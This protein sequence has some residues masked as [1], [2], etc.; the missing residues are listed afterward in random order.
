MDPLRE[1]TE[2]DLHERCRRG[3]DG[4]HGADRFSHDRQHLVAELRDCEHDDDPHDD[5][6]DRQHQEPADM[7]VEEPVGLDGLT[8]GTTAHGP[9]GVV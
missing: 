9:F 5:H 1:L 7:D 8:H 3:D 6:G 2:V 4:L